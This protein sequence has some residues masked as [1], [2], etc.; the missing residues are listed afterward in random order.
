MFAATSRSEIETSEPAR[1]QRASGRSRI[2]FR[3]R[4][5][6]T[7]LDRLYQDGC[8]KVRLPRMIREV[9]EAVLINTAGGLTG[10]DM[11]STEV[12]LKAGTQAVITTQA[13]ERIYRSPGGAA[14]IE[15]RIEIGEK[16]RLHWLPQ[17]TILFDRGRMS[18]LIEVEMASDA[19]F[20]AVES[21]IFG[22]AAMGEAV[23]AGSFRD[24]WRVRREGRLIFGDDL[25]FEGDI[26]VQLSRPAV[27]AGNAAL[28]TVLLAG[29]DCEQFLEPVRETLE[30]A[31]GASAWDGKLVVR[32]AAADGYALRRILLPVLSVVT[33]G[34]PLPKV[35]QI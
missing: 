9:P 33:A 35:W 6:V 21:L 5:D 22:R 26:A 10:G 23:T 16:A 30:E 4:G 18:R 15:A 34:R 28:A 12:R 31:G 7:C 14:R 27:L 24:R 25:R 1:L 11:L 13:C 3:R 20:L 17:E 8:A 2:V 29:P 19:E 32:I